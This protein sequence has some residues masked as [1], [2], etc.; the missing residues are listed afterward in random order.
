MALQEKLSA[1]GAKTAGD[2]NLRGSLVSFK[3]EV[4][5]VSERLKIMKKSQ[6]QL[7]RDKSEENKF[8]V[9]KWAARDIAV[10]DANHLL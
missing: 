9:R 5:R 4:E 10:L 1:E 2:E 8:H 6:L 7:L 3:L